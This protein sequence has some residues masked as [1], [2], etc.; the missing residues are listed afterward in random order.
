VQEEGNPHP[1]LLGRA[2]ATSLL[3]D[4]TFRAALISMPEA[5]GQRGRRL[6][7]SMSAA[8]VPER[9]QAHITML[10]CLSTP[11]GVPVFVYAWHGVRRPGTGAFSNEGLPGGGLPRH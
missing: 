9:S 2:A 11:R 10:L 3:L 7:R 1:A 6:L 8:A 4:L 5:Y